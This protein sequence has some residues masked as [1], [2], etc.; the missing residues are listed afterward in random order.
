MPTYHITA[1]PAPGYH[2]D[3]RTCPLV[4]QDFIADHVGEAIGFGEAIIAEDAVH[5]WQSA[6]AAANPEGGLDEEVGGLFDRPIGDTTAADRATAYVDEWCVG[7]RPVD[8]PAVDL[9][10]HGAVKV[11]IHHGQVSS[12]A[13]PPEDTGTFDV[14]LDGVVSGLLHRRPDEISGKPTW[15][16]GEATGALTTLADRRWTDYSSDYPGG[17]GRWLVR[18]VADIRAALDGK[19]AYERPVH[20]EARG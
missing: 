13:S 17:P 6:Y 1:V 15:R 4:P 19:S 18:V 3:P 14:L 20:P 12:F 7:A 11:V 8:R 9:M 5:I 10:P 2:P 16:I